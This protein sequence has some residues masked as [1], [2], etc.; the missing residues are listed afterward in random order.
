MSRLILS[1]TAAGRPGGTAMAFQ[2][3]TAKSLGPPD[4]ATVGTSGNSGERWGAARASRRS[5][6]AR[7]SG[8][9]VAALPIA[10]LMSPVETEV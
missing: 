4:S 5:L 3:V 1:V 2:P 6:P 7:Y 10:K 9:A 8:P